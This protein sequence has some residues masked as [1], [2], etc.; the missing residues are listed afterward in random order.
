MGDADFGLGVAL[1]PGV[2][3]EMRPSPLPWTRTEAEE[4]GR[5]LGVAPRLGAEASRGALLAADGPVVLHVATHGTFIDAYASEREQREPRAQV[6]E[7]RGDI[8][9]TREPDDEEGIGWSPMG[10]AT[11]DDDPSARHRRRVQWL[12]EV[13]PSEPST[14]SALLLAGFTGWLAGAPTAPDIGTGVVTAAELAL[15][16]LEATELVVLSACETG[17]SA[18]DDVDGTVLGLRTA[19]LAAGA[20]CCIASLWS[21]DDRVTAEL[22]TRMYAA[23]ADGHSWPAALRAAQ[24]AVRRHHPDPFYWAAWVAE[25][26]I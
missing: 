11:P 19:A 21:V 16:D 12:H 3:L 8:V 13:G 2:R 9:V 18:V 17:V 23:R 6:V 24:L 26:G 10:A 4:V 22:M 20:G 25:G 14:R 5:V 15:L 7:A 1:A